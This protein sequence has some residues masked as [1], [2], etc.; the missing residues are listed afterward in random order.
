M[1][2]VRHVHD[3][4][5][6][7]YASGLRG[8]DG[9][10]VCDVSP[11][12]DGIGNETYSFRLEQAGGAEG[13]GSSLILQ[14]GRD[15]SPKG[16]VCQALAG[17]AAA[18]IPVP[19]VHETGENMLGRPFIIMDRVEGRAMWC[20]AGSKRTD[21][22]HETLWRRFA[23]MLAAIHRLDWSAAGLGFLEHPRGRYGYARQ[24]LCV[25]SQPSSY[26]DA[27]LFETMPPLLDWLTENAPPSDRYVL[28]HGDYHPGNVIVRGLDI[29]AVVDWDGVSVGDPAFDVCEIPLILRIMDPACS[30]SGGMGESFVRHYAE[31]GGP[32]LTNL[33]FYLV[34][35]A[36]LFLLFL[37]HKSELR[38]DWR[39]AGVTACAGIVEER[40]GL[41][42]PLCRPAR[43]P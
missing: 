16:R 12:G 5:Q 13:Q 1:S 22:P 4:L 26:P 2:R 35:K 31:A 17:L 30:W 19:R 20:E 24:W 3:A 8:A 25:L 18:G 29:E 38:T 40:A 36:A 41:R 21:V 43:S 9:P 10:R 27:G 42:L 32:P 39:D 7:H 23:E 11:I 15:G 37:L 33:R 6:E 28:L 34:L 14:V